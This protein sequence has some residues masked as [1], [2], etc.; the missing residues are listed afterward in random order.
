MTRDEK[1]REAKKRWYKKHGK[2]YRAKNAETI[3]QSSREHYARNRKAEI[4]RAQAYKAEDPVRNLLQKAKSRARA[5]GLPCELTYE[6]LSARVAP[7]T[8]EATGVN[9]DW[10]DVRVRPSIDRLDNAK[11]YTVD[12]FRI[13]SWIFN[14]ARGPFTDEDVMEFIVKPFRTEER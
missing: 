8:C 2:A 14:R 13:T 4:A 12:N 7:M 10:G 1:K 3:N 6:L 11:G 9:L 5:K